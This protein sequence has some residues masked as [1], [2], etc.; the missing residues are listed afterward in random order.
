MYVSSWKQDPLQEYPKGGDISPSFKVKTCGPVKKKE[1]LKVVS[2]IENKVWRSQEVDPRTIRR[3]IEQVG[4]EGSWRPVIE[5]EFIP[6]SNVKSDDDRLRIA[7]HQDP[8]DLRQMIVEQSRTRGRELSQDEEKA[9]EKKFGAISKQF[10]KP[11][12]MYSSLF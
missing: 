10:L 5:P 3:S 9:L 2:S 4:R 6:D 8:W 1:A 11:S 7:N 12:A